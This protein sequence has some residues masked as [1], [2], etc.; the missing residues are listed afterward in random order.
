MKSFLSFMVVTFAMCPVFADYY[1][2]SGGG[3]YELYVTDCT[4]AGMRRALDNAT[5][6]RHAVITSVKCAADKRPRDVAEQIDWSNV[7]METIP[8]EYLCPC[9]VVAMMPCGC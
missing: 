9:S 2:A 8:A 5:A 1:R 4:T 3:V 7:Y 6:Q